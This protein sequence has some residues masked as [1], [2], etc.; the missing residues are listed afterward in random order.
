MSGKTFQD[1]T[2]GINS[3]PQAVALSPL[4]D[5]T[6]GGSGPGNSAS[7]AYNGFIV[8]F[9]ADATDGQKATAA[10]L[11]GGSISELVRLGSGGAGDLVVIDGSSQDQSRAL[12]ALSHAPGVSFAEV[13]WT[14]TTQAAADDTYYANGSQWGAYGNLTAPPNTFGTQAGEAWAAGATGK[15]NVVVGNIDTG[16][17]YTHPDLYLN[18]WLNQGELPTGMALADVN[19]DGLITFRDLNDAANASFVTDVNGNGRIDAGDLLKDA[20]WA[21]GVDGDGNGYVDDLIGWNF[22]NN[23]NDPY[24]D[25]N[26]GTHTSGTI[27]AIG[28]NGT[29]VAGM[30]WNVQI[31]AMKFLSATG[32]GSI[33]N[34]V[35]AEDYF[36]KVAAQ[37][38]SAHLPAEF[39][40][41]NNSWGGGGFSQAMQDAITRGAKQ[42]L[43]FIAAAGNGGS[44][45]RGDNNDSV[46]NY[47]SNYSTLSSAGY[48][49][50]VAV[51]A[52][53]S[54]GAL[55][56][57]SNYGV[58]TVDLAAPGSGIWSTVA[59]GGYASYSGTSMATPHVT[60][61]VALL[62]SFNSLL[63]AAQLRDALLSSAVETPGAGGTYT[64]GRL[65][66]HLMIDPVNGGSPGS[67]PVT[68]VSTLYGSSS[69]SETLT[70][71][72]YRDIISG[73][74]A[75]G[76]NPGRGTID[77]LTGGTGNDVFM[78]GDVR[79]RFYDDGSGNSPGKTD[80]AMIGDFTTG[81][82]VQL[83]KG[84]YFLSAV[85]VNNVSGLG[86]FHDSNNNHSF[87]SADELI[88]VLKGV[89][90]GFSGADVIWA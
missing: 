22:V 63:S 52:L 69:L 75:T 59:G 49:S 64:G 55:A 39:I 54:T 80:Y 4:P 10:A 7:A 72:A 33:A 48:E 61:G 21:N 43:L 88:G 57:F 14:V 66:L 73:V 41:T 76:S 8:Q 29:G 68:S 35:L 47:P 70:G 38:Q 17:D 85:T 44:D 84:N 28:G 67:N 40:A 26:H 78:L 60:G 87:G 79:G 34:A 36:T 32:S 53:T 1:S 74:A 5:E 23:D 19:G 89:T 45:G 9:T 42:D 62:A 25:N 51:A 71:G 16:I 18:V 86:I 15:S 81:D 31:A 58:K 90:T 24:D 20:R 83:K 12:A 30:A 65:D 50:V 11:I 2:N 6:S 27:G 77:T 13:N 46:A 56:S 37:S 82:M 3:T